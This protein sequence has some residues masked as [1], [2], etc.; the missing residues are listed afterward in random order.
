[1]M[2]EGC[3]CNVVVRPRPS[4]VRAGPVT[5][6]TFGGD[7]RPGVPDIRRWLIQGSAVHMCIR[8]RVQRSFIN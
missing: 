2:E 8:W 3:V 5:I 7:P 1:M 4:L 6:A